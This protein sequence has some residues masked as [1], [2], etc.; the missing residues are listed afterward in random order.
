MEDLIILLKNISGI[1]GA[2]YCFR[3]PRDVINGTSLATKLSDFP[4]NY[5]LLK[6]CNLQPSKLNVEGLFY[7]TTKALKIEVI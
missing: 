4:R 7:L 3:A 1:R 5:T 6:C 2:T